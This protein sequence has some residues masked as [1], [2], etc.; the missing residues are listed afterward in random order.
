MKRYVGVGALFLLASCADTQKQTIVDQQPTV[1]ELAAWSEDD[2]QDLDVEVAESSHPYENYSY[3]SWRIEVPECAQAVR[4]RFDRVATEYRYDAL[5]LFDRDGQIVQTLTGEYHD[6]VS[7]PVTGHIVDLLLYS[8]FS[9]TD[10]GFEVASVQAVEGLLSCPRYMWPSCDEGTVEVFTEPEFCTCPRPPTCQSLADFSA[11]ITTGGGFSGLTEGYTVAGDNSVYRL[12]GFPGQV[13]ETLIAAAHPVAVQELARALIGQG[14]FAESGTS[15]ETANMTSALHATFGG[16]SRTITWPMGSEAPKEIESALTAWK[17]VLSCDGGSEIESTCVS[18]NACYQN[19]CTSPD[20]SVVRC[21]SGTECEM[22]VRECQQP[23]CAPVASCEPI[24]APTCEG[25]ACEDGQHCE[26]IQVQ[27][28]AAPCPPMPTCVP[29]EEPCICTEQYAP[30]CGENYVTYGNAC[31]ANCEA[32]AILH[33]GECGTAGDQCGTIRGLTCLEDFQCRYGVGQ[34]DAPYPD[35]GGECVGFG[36]CEEVVDCNIYPHI[37]CVGAWSCLDNHCSYDCGIGP[38]EMWERE[39]AS[40]GS[41]NPYADDQTLAWRVTG[42]EGTR[43]VRVVFS[44]FDLEEG[45][46]F[47]TLYDASWNPVHVYTGNLGAFTSDPID[48]EMIYVG[49]E[50]DGSITAAGFHAEAVEFLQ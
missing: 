15:G 14:F 31:F 24:D 8:D 22:V 40:F 5:Y 47:V 25:V 45:Y 11:T 20:C 29:D 17:S 37:M 46:D 41:P 34:Y 44:S 49:F 6:L 4:L 21:A 2:W 1:A 12:S 7:E 50:S 30:V 35:A 39:D 9:I 33:T 23:P 26:L 42:N 43:A 38:L 10:W 13:N 48:G 18:N 19:V 3:E 16:V 36:F 32:V 27:C 28:F